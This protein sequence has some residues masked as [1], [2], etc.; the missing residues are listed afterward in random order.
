MYV[1]LIKLFTHALTPYK[2]VCFENIILLATSMSNHSSVALA[3]Q[4]MATCIT[5]SPFSP[6]FLPP[7]CHQLH[8]CWHMRSFANNRHHP[9]IDLNY[10]TQA[11]C[12]IVLSRFCLYSNRVSYIR[13]FL[14]RFMYDIVYV[15]STLASFG[16]WCTR[17]NAMSNDPPVP[18]YGPSVTTYN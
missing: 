1:S 5:S 4:T 8:Q 11:I 7:F 6:S 12:L 10:K 14:L 9:H 15:C 16:I 3:I 17:F 13:T 18:S 2:T